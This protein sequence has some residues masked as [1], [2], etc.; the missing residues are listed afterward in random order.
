[1]QFFHHM[2][3]ILQLFELFWPLAL[4]QNI[5]IETNRYVTERLDAHGNIRGGGERNGRILQWLG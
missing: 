5:V 3:T 4:M 1:M 2:P